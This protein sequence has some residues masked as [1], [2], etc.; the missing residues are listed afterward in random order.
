MNRTRPLT[1]KEHAE[2]I[3]F[4]FGS[5]NYGNAVYAEHQYFQARMLAATS[6]CKVKVRAAQ[7]SANRWAKVQNHYLAE[8]KR[9]CEAMGYKYVTASGR[10]LIP[11][12]G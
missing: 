9:E 2:Y 12:K 7:I 4:K 11:T 6:K 3:Q 1:K 10:A 8:F 5:E